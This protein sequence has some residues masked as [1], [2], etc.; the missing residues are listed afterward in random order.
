MLGVDPTS[1][2]VTFDTPQ[3]RNLLDGRNVHYVPYVEPRDVGNAARAAKQIVPLIRVVD[4][5]VST[6]AALAVSVLPQVRARRKPAVYIESISRVQGPSLSGRLLA[7]TP[8]I[9]VY[10]QHTGWLHSPWLAGPSVLAAYKKLTDPLARRLPR[11]VLVTLGT[12]AP[13]RFDRLIDAVLGYAARH[14]N[15]EFVWQVGVTSR[16]DLPG[17]VH[18]MMEAG[19]FVDALAWADVV[20]SHAGVGTAMQILDTGHVP[21]LL[22]RLRQ[23]KEHVDDHQRQISDFLGERQLAYSAIGALKSDDL[24]ADIVAMRILIDPRT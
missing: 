17:R 14:E 19:E 8:G 24:M 20:V 3:S 5:A 4:G 11:R 2:W 21:L 16:S 22:P 6:G 9:G 13:Y 15:T 7:H 10:A 1:P 12:I 23:F 18:P